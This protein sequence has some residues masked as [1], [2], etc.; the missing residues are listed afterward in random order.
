MNTEEK[1]ISI[2]ISFP[3]EMI[4]FLDQEAARNDL[5]R[6]Q[7]VRMAVRNMQ[8]YEEEKKPDEKEGKK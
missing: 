3:E 4:K 6:S 8:V 1:F 2:T 7:V 5:N